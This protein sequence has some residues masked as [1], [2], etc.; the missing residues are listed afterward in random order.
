MD[1]NLR[2]PTNR[3]CERCGRKEEWDPDAM[4]WRI[5]VE[6]NERQVGEPF[7]IHEWDITGTF[8]PFE[9]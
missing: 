4:S 8:V 3:T 2:R 5:T 7:C 1:S 9:N 6:A